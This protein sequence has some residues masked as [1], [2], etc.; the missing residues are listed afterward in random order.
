MQIRFPQTLSTSQWEVPA[1]KP[2]IIPKSVYKFYPGNK[3]CARTTPSSE[4]FVLRAVT[5][6]KRSA[7]LKHHLRLCCTPHWLVSLSLA[8]PDL[9]QCKAAWNFGLTW[10]RWRWSQ[11]SEQAEVGK[12]LPLPAHT[13]FTT[14]LNRD[15]LGK[16]L[17]L[18]PTLEV[19]VITWDAILSTLF[20]LFYNHNPGHHL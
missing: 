2:R 9:S 7:L 1:I 6:G 19:L 14:G 5:P 15:F 18:R 16:P 4:P 13:R 10:P 11:Q 20:I 12:R 8:Q 3:R 17:I